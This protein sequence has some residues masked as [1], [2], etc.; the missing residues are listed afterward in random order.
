MN[1]ESEAIYAALAAEIGAG[2]LDTLYL[3]LD[4]V[5]ARLAPPTPSAGA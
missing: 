3:L 4:E 1:A 2:N 5:L